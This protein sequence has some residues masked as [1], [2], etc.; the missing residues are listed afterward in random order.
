MI[1]TLAVFIF[2]IGKKMNQI[3]KPV[4]LKAED[5]TVIERSGIKEVVKH[6]VSHFFL[7]MLEKLTKRFKL[8]SLKSHNSLET[9]SKKIRE[10][11]ENRLRLREELKQQRKAALAELKMKEGTSEAVEN[12]IAEISKTEIAPQIKTEKVVSPMVREEVV[13][14]EPKEEAKGEYESALIERIAM[15]PRDIEAYERLGDYYVEQGN[16]VDAVECFKQM[17]KLSPGNRKAKLAI[18]KLDKKI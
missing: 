15:N 14:P 18:R 1:V 9:L 8:M 17:V 7:Q 6:R 11:K 4:E 3:P 12:V 10:K 13:H 16:S 5:G 2:F